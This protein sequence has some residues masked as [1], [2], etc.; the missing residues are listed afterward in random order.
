M[1]L[2]KA[3]SSLQCARALVEVSTEP[4]LVIDA[5]LRIRLASPAFLSAMG[6]TN[7]QV[8]Q[9]SF[10]E[11]AGGR[12]NIPGLIRLLESTLSQGQGF[13]QVPVELELPG[14][15]HRRLLLSGRRFGDSDPPG[16]VLISV[17]DLTP[18]ESAQRE[19]ERQRQWFATTLS[20]IGD[21]V[22][23]TDTHARV[24]FM[25]PSA[26]RLTGWSLGDAR[27]RDLIEVF[28]IVNE[29]TRA[30]VESPVTKALRDGHV[31][32]LAN[33]TVLIARDGKEHP[34]DDSAAPIRD[35]S[36]EVLGVVLVFHDITERHAADQ[37]QA[38]LVEIVE[39]SDD[40]IAA[41]DLQGNITAWNKGAQR[42]FGYTAEEALGKSI[43]LIIPPDRWDEEK[44][45]LEK[46]R[47]G[48]RID[49]FETVRQCKDGSLVDISLTVSPLR[50]RKGEI[51]GASKIA[52]DITERKRIQRQ[53]QTHLMNEQALRLEAEN[54]NRSKDLFLATLS[55]ELRTPL[56][57]IVGWMSILRSPQRTPEDLE[58]GLDV[59]ERNTR[60]QMQLIE[61]VLDISRIVSGKLTLNIQPCDFEN[62]IRAALD[63]VR[64]AAAARDIALDVVID[65]L[66]KAGACDPARLQQIV[67]NLLSN[68]VKFTP[69][70]GRVSVTLSRHESRTRIVVQDTGIG[71][72]AEFLPYVFQRFRQA[73]S[74]TR[75][76][77]GGLGLGLSIVKQL[78]ELHGG[79]VQAQSAGENQGS[80]F[81][82]ELPIAAVN[83]APAGEPTA[84]A[85]SQRVA[86]PVAP[87]V[88]LD[89]LHVLI[90]D[91]EPDARNLLSRVFVE[92]GARVT[93]AGSADEAIA[94]IQ[95][96]QPHVMVSD[97][98]MPEKDG[99]D[100]IRHL[101][102][103]GLGAKAL[104]AV[105][106][107]AFAQK[108]DARAAIL[109]GYQ[110]HIAKPVDPRDLLAAVASLADRT[111]H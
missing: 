103:N 70:G 92:A 39:S 14:L 84:V 68:A 19:V 72:S 54:A 78:V 100:L 53:L 49:H 1:G 58:E 61:E 108:E 101:R 24:T 111:G 55:H 73:D 48:E 56:N 90:V 99:Y 82:V 36:G 94:A 20:S 40:A 65:P 51:I 86:A 105:A 47:Q 87:A 4:L 80:T 106:L 102:G 6:L 2:E 44:K 97:I 59:I 12:W 35:P 37:I 52:R 96:R 75:R 16:L 8:L 33:H 67:W 64:P 63:S 25:N 74:S 42:L 50:N 34:I 32:G 109:A 79:T 9:Q 18:Q 17:A 28:H 83:M 60:I 76:R 57:A 77:F 29:D 71:L 45:V 41:K 107:T 23:A 95:R 30:L 110:V 31:V 62:T 26:E 88:R 46:I 10:K 22:I 69:K 21:A 13:D 43:T 93:L 15:G 11:L 81:I 85:S 7:E 98:A 3:D 5:E 89:G 104:P 91:D 27:G 38:R 66:A